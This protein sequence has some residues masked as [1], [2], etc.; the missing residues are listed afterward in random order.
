[1]NSLNSKLNG[2]YIGFIVLWP[3]LQYFI[4]FDGKGRIPF[5][6]TL[7]FLAYSFLPIKSN[8]IYASTNMVDMGS[9]CFD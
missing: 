8:F 2:F 6:G 5:F 1:M 9:V 3:V 7:A 4:G